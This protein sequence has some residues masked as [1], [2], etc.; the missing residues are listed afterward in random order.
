LKIFLNNL[1]DLNRLTSLELDGETYAIKKIEKNDVKLEGKMQ[2]MKIEVKSNDYNKFEKLLPLYLEKLVGHEDFKFVKQEYGVE[3]LNFFDQ[4]F[5][6]ILSSKNIDFQRVTIKHKEA[7]KLLDHEVFW[8]KM[9][10]IRT[11]LVITSESQEYV[12]LYLSNPNRSG[13]G[14]IKEIKEIIN[15]KKDSNIFLIEY[16][17]QA[18]LNKVLDKIHKDIKIQ[19]FYD[20][21]KSF[22]NKLGKSNKLIKI[23]NGDQFPFSLILKF[24]M[25]FQNFK[26][27]IL[28]L[29]NN[30]VTIKESNKDQIEIE[31]YPSQLLESD[32]GN[33]I[34]SIMKKY[35]CDEW[36][37]QKDKDV[38]EL[39]KNKLQKF[40]EH[41]YNLNLILKLEND[42]SLLIRI[43]C[44]SEMLKTER[45]KIDDIINNE[46]NEKM[47]EKVNDKNYRC[48]LLLKS[49]FIVQCRKTCAD[50]MIKIDSTNEIITFNGFFDSVIYCKQKMAE[51]FNSIRSKELDVS[52]LIA[53]FLH[54]RREYVETIIREKELKCVY[55]INNF[56]EKD[57]DISFKL[58]LYSIERDELSKTEN[59]IRNSFDE[60]KYNLKEES[61][62]L[63]DD[64]YPEFIRNFEEEL[65]AKNKHERF[66]F[67]PKEYRKVW[68]VGE[69]SIVKAAK[70]CIVKFFEENTIHINYCDWL[71]QEN[72][73]YLNIVISKLLESLEKEKLSDKIKFEKDSDKLSLKIE[74]NKLVYGE[75]KRIIDDIINKKKTEYYDT[76]KCVIDL[77]TND[78]NKR[79]LLDNIEKENKCLI[80][81]EADEEWVKIEKEEE[82][83]VDAIFIEDKRLFREISSNQFQTKII[84]SEKKVEELS[85]VDAI[86]LPFYTYL[87]P[88]NNEA[89]LIID[90][91]KSFEDKINK[92][93]NKKFTEGEIFE[94]QLNEKNKVNNWKCIILAFIPDI[95]TQTGIT[96]IQLSETI[97]RSL[98]RLGYLKYKSI[99]FPFF[100]TEKQSSEIDSLIG[101][102]VQNT[103]IYLMENP[104]LNLQEINFVDLKHSIKFLK[105]FET[106]LTDFAV[107]FTNIDKNI[108]PIMQNK[109]TKTNKNEGR[110]VS[111]NIEIK[112]GSILDNFN[113]D[114]IV[115][116]TSDDLN[117][118][119]GAVSKLILQKAGDVIQQDLNKNYPKGLENNASKVAISTSGNI[120]NLKRI[121]HISLKSF[122]ATAEIEKT[123]KDTLKEI[124]DICDQNNFNSVA[125]PA[126][127]TGVLGYDRNTV[128]EWMFETTNEY[129]KTNTNIKKV[130]FVL[131]DKDVAT[132]DAF[133]NYKKNRY[134]RE[135]IEAED[136]EIDYLDAKR[137]S[138]DI[139]DKFFTDLNGDTENGYKMMFR[140]VTVHVYL[141]DITKAREDVII[142]P[143]REDFNLNGFVSRALVD[144][145]GSPFKNELNKS[146]KLDDKGTLFT[147]AGNLNAKTILHTAI[148][149]N[150]IEKSVIT[151]LLK[152]N[153]KKYESV[154]FPVIGT[155]NM[156]A[157][158]KI[159]INSMFVGFA[160]YI[161][162]IIKKKKSS[163]K[164][165]K[166]CIYEKQKEMLETFYGEMKALEAKKP[167]SS[168]F[169]S[170]LSK[171]GSLRSYL[172]GN[173]SGDY[174]VQEVKARTDERN[175]RNKVELSKYKFKLIS[176]D[177]QS[178]RKTKEQLRDLIENEMKE[179]KIDHEYIE[180]IEKRE[181]QEIEEI[182]YK[183]EM[184]CIIDKKLKFI[185]IEGLS[186]LVLDCFTELQKYL[187]NK[188]KKAVNDAI[189]LSRLIIWE[190]SIDNR[191]WHPYDIHL[192]KNIINA[193]NH[194]EKKLEFENENREKF[195]IDFGTMTQEKKNSKTKDKCYIRCEDLKSRGI[196]V[197]DYWFKDK[198]LNLIL[199]DNTTQEYKN[200]VKTL[201]DNKYGNHTIISIERIQNERLYIQ[202]TAHRKS[203]IDRQD[204]NGLNEK[205]AF[206]GTTG[207]TVENIWKGGFNRSYCGK[208]A[209]VYGAG[210][211]FARDASYSH[212]Y[213]NLGG[214]AKKG[215]NLTQ[216]H[217]FVC[218]V[219]VGFN[220]LGNSSIQTQNLPKA[221][222]GT[223]SVDSTVD[224]I[225]N[226]S[227]FVIYH[228][229]QAYPEYLITYQ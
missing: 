22:E 123:F 56:N 39:I 51:F 210:V 29:T 85:D 80:R 190:Y 106:C 162:K 134:S 159:A 226:P 64:K 178:I 160:F 212:G 201:K 187:N 47:I 97:S 15:P 63:F 183:Y 55:S 68:C 88:F 103:I 83:I 108:L 5:T 207:D 215:G 109:K 105:S 44:T 199:I 174:Q 6:V 71:N 99:A 181:E 79:F 43:E 184:K 30:F 100:Y 138:F 143:T 54:E 155:G 19:L 125:M 176:D 223:T 173:N 189:E 78:R 84:I 90:S 131:Y 217:L 101:K 129:L 139:D 188:N 59:L 197:P 211:Y 60:F 23:L 209:T 110:Y 204:P 18:S 193:R 192:N 156:A 70:E 203:F 150:E 82:K 77:F 117:L 42:E 48:S 171:I 50:M 3:F 89:Q 116:T 61:E 140:D 182:C 195:I 41:S 169:G 87:K 7:P 137:E 40:Y 145:A 147:T 126:F 32:L 213:T 216:A 12:K 164:T 168:F 141:G 127:G 191:T 225:Q 185:K 104:K 180:K 148:I 76:K 27:D 112:I 4:M 151:A 8:E 111:P 153:D 107:K 142:N 224:N 121:F 2:L 161:D 26:N 81:N 75:V 167:S 13:G 94:I 113:V 93:K 220:A 95:T 206:H 91:N 165:I 158:H 35:C 69:K 53:Y 154:V 36:K 120:R 57:F 58:S 152:I 72:L 228:D 38:I 96:D 227:I 208:N 200:V 9:T 144:A 20:D 146:L 130:L 28:K 149:G 21:I 102:I 62:N 218:K 17:D 52:F 133:Q 135:V 219:L 177:E 16:E 170:V 118:K 163:I 229:A 186:N 33:H 128:A 45:A 179:Q 24:A 10:D 194:N 221:P 25:Y 86:V 172:F 98:Q 31:Y 14:K 114:V 214:V 11:V 66:L 124:L 222:D 202:Y 115:N 122:E 46:R 136:I 196:G 157:D 198:N 37:I 74:S 65:K 205:T 1:T 175:E 34:D 92:L 73:N 119:N 49:G 132:I 67:F 166:I